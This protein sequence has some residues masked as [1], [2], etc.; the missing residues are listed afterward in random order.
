MDASEPFLYTG[1]PNNEI[2][3][4]VTDVRVDPSIKVIKSHAFQGCKKLRNVELCD[5]LE[6]IESW[7]FDGSSITTMIIPSTVIKIGEEAFMDCD[8]LTTV[9]LC[10]GLERIESGAFQSCSSLESIS[11]PSTVKIIDWN[12]FWDCTQLRNVE[13][14]D[15]LIRIE[16]FAF[17]GCTSL[18]NLTIPT[19]VKYIN[20]KAFYDCTTMEGID[21]CE[22]INQFVTEAPLPWWNG[23]VSLAAVMTYSFLMGNN[24]PSRL[25]DI[26]ERAWTINI[27]EMLQHIPDKLKDRSNDDDLDKGSDD[28]TYPNCDKKMVLIEIDDYFDFVKYRLSNYEHVQEGIAV[29]ERAIMKVTCHDDYALVMCGII[30]PNVLP[31][32]LDESNCPHT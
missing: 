22:E 1:Q 24:I 11:I 27:H 18:T 2:P 5:G 3:H 25:S 31:F 26:K 9:E 29:L 14:H 30:I 8:Y 13:L 15:G 4:D 20:E 28:D 10:E 7:A 19:S 16:C 32:V 21:Y 12:T 6:T 17:E 23:G